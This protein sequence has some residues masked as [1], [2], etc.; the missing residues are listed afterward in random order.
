MSERALTGGRQWTKDIPNS[1]A[2]FDAIAGTWSATNGWETQGTEAL[3][4]ETYWDMS[5]YTLDDLTF[6]PI[7]AVLQDGM[8]YSMIFTTTTDQALSVID[9]VSQERLDIAQVVADYGNGVTLNLPGQPLSTENFEQII[10]E[11]F[12]LMLPQVDFTSA[13]LVLPATTGSYG[14]LQP[15]ACEKLWIYRIILI[16]GALETGNTVLV[17]ATRFVMSGTVVKEPE[18]DYMMRLKR[19]FE[20][21]Q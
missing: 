7:S 15:T 11:N 20:L 9:I 19:S 5:A 3:Y 6:F 12:R 16:A 17:P 4:Y 21:S 18:L 14:S 8:P 10:M 2:T 13:T 1:E